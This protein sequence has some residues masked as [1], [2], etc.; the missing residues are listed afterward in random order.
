M[1]DEHPHVTMFIV[2]PSSRIQLEILSAHEFTYSHRRA[3]HVSSTDRD[4]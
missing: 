2:L 3:Y 4:K 1:I